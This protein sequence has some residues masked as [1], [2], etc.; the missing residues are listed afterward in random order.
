M[1]RFVKQFN[2]ICIFII[3]KYFCF[4]ICR[5]KFVLIFALNITYLFLCNCQT[6][7]VFCENNIHHVLSTNAKTCYM[8]TKTKIGSRGFRISSQ[9][10]DAVK[11]LVFTN[12]TN[13]YYLPNNAAGK[14]PEM[15][16]YKAGDCSIKKI[17][18]LNFKGLTKLKQLFLNNNQ[19]RTIESETFEDLINLEQVF[20][21]K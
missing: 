1:K 3:K 4:V 15:T 12:N 17:S 19:L 9:R 5:D 14:F 11:E 13:I 10:S 7:K 20:L 16:E 18:K 8:D 6:K 21:C 2:F